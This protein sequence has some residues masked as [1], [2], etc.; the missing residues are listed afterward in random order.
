ML[1]GSLSPYTVVLGDQVSPESGSSCQAL[2]RPIPIGGSL[3]P[4]RLRSQQVMA[5]KG[6]SS[7]SSM[8]AQAFQ[9][10]S[11]PGSLASALVDRGEY[12][13]TKAG[14]TGET[15]TCHSF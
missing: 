8:G 9:H 12:L 4:E 14:R 10:S 11:P 1:I 13:R 3:A 2:K 5:L 7:V 15:K 6:L